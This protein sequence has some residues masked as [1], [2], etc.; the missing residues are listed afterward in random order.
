M[1]N[2]QGADWYFLL[3]RLLVWLR[4]RNVNRY[5]TAI[6]Q[7][8]YASSLY[9]CVNIALAWFHH[10]C[11]RRRRARDLFITGAM[12]VLLLLC[13]NSPFLLQQFLKP[14]AFSFYIS[15]RKTTIEQVLLYGCA[16]FDQ[17]YDRGRDQL[18]ARPDLSFPTR[19]K[20]FS[21]LQRGGNDK[22]GRAEA[23][24]YLNNLS[25]ENIGERTI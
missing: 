19:C 3:L 2:G 17:C 23:G 1:G 5:F 10:C 11:S 25:P 9:S 8:L 16:I 13:R 14:A 24:P 15:S 7:P 22:S 18:L 21:H 4:K 12:R 6:S 20:R